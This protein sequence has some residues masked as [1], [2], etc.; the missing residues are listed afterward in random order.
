MAVDLSA[1]LFDPRE[2]QKFSPDKATVV[3]VHK[4]QDISVVVWNLEPGQMNALHKHAQN[5]HAMLILE[6]TGELLRGDESPLPVSAG[7]WLVVPRTQPHG[8]RNTGTGRL[9]YL[10]VT[11]EGAQGYVKEEL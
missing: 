4:D 11:N 7:D 9:S 2:A 10:A 3:R 5:A 6:G 8:I 1:R